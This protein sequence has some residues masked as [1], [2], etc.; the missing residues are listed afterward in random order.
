LADKL[1]TECDGM[2]TLKERKK[3]RKEWMN[4]WRKEQMNEEITTYK[5]LNMTQKGK[6]PKGG[7]RSWR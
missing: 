7:L 4:E 2:G 6:R 5:I 1:T 3:E